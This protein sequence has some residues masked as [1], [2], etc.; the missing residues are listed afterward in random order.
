[1]ITQQP[2]FYTRDFHPIANAKL[3]GINNDLK[4][5]TKHVFNHRFVRQKKQ[6]IIINT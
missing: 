3:K 1:M 6:N 5:D 2:T 4:V